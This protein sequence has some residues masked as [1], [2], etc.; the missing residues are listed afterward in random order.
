MIHRIACFVGRPVVCLAAC[1]LSGCKTPKEPE[2]VRPPAVHVPDEVAREI[3]PDKPF[4]HRPYELIWSN[5]REDHK[6]FV[7]F[8]RVADWSTV[9]SGSLTSRFERTRDKQLWGSHVGRLI[10]GGDAEGKLIQIVPPEALPIKDRFDCIG[11]WMHAPTPNLPHPI[12][13]AIVLEGGDGERHRF[14]LAESPASGWRFVHRP[15]TEDELEAIQFPCR[16]AAIEF[17]PCAGVE[18]VT[19]YMDSL[20]FF[21]RR[22]NELEFEPRPAPN[23]D[24]TGF[25]VQDDNR[26]PFPVDPW[27]V[28]PVSP[29]PTMKNR[30]IRGEKDMIRLECAGRDGTLVYQLDARKGLG[31]LEA[32]FNESRVGRLMTGGGIDTG[33]EKQELAV[34]RE[35]RNGVRMQ[36]QDGS[37]YFLQVRGKTL[38]VDATRRGVRSGRFRAGAFTEL[39]NARRLDI[40][41]LRLSD[42]T[43]PGVIT[44]ETHGGETSFRLF[45]SVAMDWTRSQASRVFKPESAGDDVHRLFG[46]TVYEP[47]TDGRQKDLSERLVITLSPRLEEVLPRLPNPPGLNTAVTREKIWSGALTEVDLEREL[48]RCRRL[49]EL[50]LT[51]V[52]YHLGS[53]IWRDHDEGVGCRSRAAPGRGGDVKLARF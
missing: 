53:W 47:S 29:D 19:L 14:V 17:S 15:L 49:A 32:W 43:E 20:A 39:K 48:E 1:W 31:A 6:P 23:I 25:E 50:G 11:F 51:E 52:I 5:R 7:D 40:P 41:F 24:L 12:E 36:Y 22:L 3:S 21:S 26:L 34:L 44:M 38:I 2:P 13:A 4:D 37:E 27:T 33:T 30:V 42:G 10:F 9:N 8:S 35:E 28:A 46:G 18:P 16:M 45:G